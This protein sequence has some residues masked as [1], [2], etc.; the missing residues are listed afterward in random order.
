MD[1]NVRYDPTSMGLDYNLD[2]TW[3]N[4]SQGLNL[5]EWDR[6]AEQGFGLLFRHTNVTAEQWRDPT[7]TTRTWPDPP[8]ARR[9][10]SFDAHLGVH[11]GNTFNVTIG[12]VQGG[13]GYEGV[14][15]GQMAAVAGGLCA[16]AA[17]AGGPPAPC[18]PCAPAPA[19]SAGSAHGS[20]R[21]EANMSH[22]RTVS[23]INAST[24]ASASAARWAACALLLDLLLEED[25]EDEEAEARV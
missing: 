2:D 21:G 13:S 18:E 9:S 17:G 14:T 8:I 23:H 22:S 19:A 15:I 3:A 6:F 5:G 1:P 10:W 12:S 16:F 11:A 20:S 7:K 25:E 24:A 4:A